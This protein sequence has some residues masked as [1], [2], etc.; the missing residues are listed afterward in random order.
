MTVTGC[1]VDARPDGDPVFAPVFLQHRPE[2]LVEILALQTHRTAKNAFL[3][4]A[5]L[6]QRAVRP[7]VAQEHARLETVRPDRSER[8]R[9][10]QSRRLEEHAAA[11]RRWSDRALALGGFECRIELPHLEQPDSGP[12]RGQR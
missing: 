8:E 3:Y 2:H 6:A 5:E 9:S 4:R 11:A 10:H 12:R 1:L 7:A